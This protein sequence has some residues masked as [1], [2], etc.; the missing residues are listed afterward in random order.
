MPDQRHAALADALWQAETSRNPIEPLTDQH[1]DLVI[2]DA[3]AIQAINVQR[4]IDNGAS[5]V[6]RKVGLTSKP[7]QQLLGVNEPDYGVLLDDMYVEEGDQVDLDRLIQPRIEAELAFILDRDLQGPGVTT[8]KAL[9][10]IGGALPALEIV[11]SRV[12]DWRIKLIDTVSDNASCGLLT[13][14][15]RITKITDLDVRL[16]GTALYRNGEVIDTGAG[17]AALGNPVRC[18]AWLANKFATFGA[19]LSA[20]DVILPGAVHKMVPVKSGDTFRADFAHVGAVTV[21]FS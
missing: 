17:A 16:V 4:R 19:S 11:D 7:M 15:G 12:V 21:T 1:D 20:G 18:V 14:G 5:V 9:A 8:A 6:G 2:E 3:Y 10:A 13:V